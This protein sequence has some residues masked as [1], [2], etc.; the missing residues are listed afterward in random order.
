MAAVK[1]INEYISQFPK[2]VGKM[3]KQIRQTARK[4]APE[5]KEV[6]SYGIP[7]LMVEGKAWEKYILHFGAYKTHVS[8]FGLSSAAM[9]PFKKELAPYLTPKGALQFALDEPLPLT[10][11]GKVVRERAK[12]ER[13]RAKKEKTG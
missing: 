5:A 7:T 8:L 11:I 4:A 10:L 9:K 13:A 1:T 12:I 3:L 6:I 2:P